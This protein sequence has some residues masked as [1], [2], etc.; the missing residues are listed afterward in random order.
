MEREVTRQALPELWTG[1]MVTQNEI[2][3][4]WDILFCKNRCRKQLFLWPFP[5]SNPN[6]PPHLIPRYFGEIFQKR[7]E[8]TLLL[9]NPSVSSGVSQEKNCTGWTG[10]GVTW[11]PGCG[12]AAASLSSHHAAEQE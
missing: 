2:I 4:I 3:S 5:S 12:G 9:Q 1:K 7:G 10:A 11:E 6:T 8:N